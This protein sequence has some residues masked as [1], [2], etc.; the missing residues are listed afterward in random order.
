MMS[1]LKDS[2]ILSISKEREAG[3]EIDKLARY[4]GISCATYFKTTGKVYVRTVC[5]TGKLAR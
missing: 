1:R 5:L 2:Q 3:V 4:Y